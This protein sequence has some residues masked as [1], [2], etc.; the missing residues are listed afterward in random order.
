MQSQQFQQLCF[1]LESICRY[2]HAVDL[3]VDVISD[4][5]KI[6]NRLL[7]RKTIFGK[8]GQNPGVSP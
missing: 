8:F 5:Y 7:Y 2:Q 4:Q 3:C 1:W 6:S